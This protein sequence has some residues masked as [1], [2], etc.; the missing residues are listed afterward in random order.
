MDFNKIIEKCKTQKTI[1]THLVLKTIVFLQT[2]LQKMKHKNQ[3]LHREL[4]AKNQGLAR[5]I[6]RLQAI[7]RKNHG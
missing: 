5:E 4:N 2:E 6:K 1:S 7:K 3:K